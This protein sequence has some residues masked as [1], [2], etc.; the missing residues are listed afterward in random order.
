[1]GRVLPI[2]PPSETPGSSHSRG[3]IGEMSWARAGGVESLLSALAVCGNQGHLEAA[4]RSDSVNREGWPGRPDGCS[5]AGVCLVQVHRA[6][7]GGAGLL[8]ASIKADSPDVQRKWAG[9]A[10]GDHQTDLADA[11]RVEGGRV[12]HLA[13]TEGGP[14]CRE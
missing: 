7:S 14:E 2:E 8:F 6:V 4:S 3:R 10:V 1:M 5:I 13:T 12:G 11:R 9:L